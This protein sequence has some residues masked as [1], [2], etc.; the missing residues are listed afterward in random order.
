MKQ[1]NI[2]SFCIDAFVYKTILMYYVNKCIHNKNF[3]CFIKFIIN[4]NEQCRLLQGK[5]VRCC[6]L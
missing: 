5:V 1:A 2:L 3:T 4:I 6:M